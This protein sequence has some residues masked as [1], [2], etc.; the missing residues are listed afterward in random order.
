MAMTDTK[1][2]SNAPILPRREYGKNRIPLSIIGLGGVVVMGVEQNHANRVVA[3]AVERGV[4]YFD[5]APTYGDAE[6]KY[7]PALE[8]YRKD[9]FLACKTTQRGREGAAAELKDSL[10]RLRTDYLDLY[11]QLLAK[12]RDRNGVGQRG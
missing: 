3:E 1:V 10:S 5:V 9:I 2:S 4:N 11:Q 8:P 6:V 12:G 7:G